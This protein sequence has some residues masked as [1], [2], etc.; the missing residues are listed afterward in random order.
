MITGVCLWKCT[1]WISAI[2]SVNQ[3]RRMLC[4]CYWNLFS[5]ARYQSVLLDWFCG[6]ENVLTRGEHSLITFRKNEIWLDLT[7][8]SIDF[9][10]RL[11]NIFLDHW[12]AFIQTQAA[13]YCVFQD[14][15]LDKK[16]FIKRTKHNCFFFNYYLYVM[17][18]F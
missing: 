16:L 5:V 2:W 15:L 6:Y 11:I 1:W 7:D 13:G 14:L 10:V 18:A 3:Y 17:C 8:I 9:L 12:I 4:G